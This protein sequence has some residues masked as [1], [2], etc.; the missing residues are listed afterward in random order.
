[1]GS[2]EKMNWE[3]EYTVLDN[4]NIEW[5]ISKKFT[6]FMHVCSVCRGLIWVFLIFIL[7][8]LEGNSGFLFFMSKNIFLILIN[9]I[10]IASPVLL[11]ELGI[12]M[13]APIVT[14][15]AIDFDNEQHR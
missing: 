4:T 6:A 8:Y 11:F 2:L 12:L 10:L 7:I 3:N 5:R 13:Y 14:K 9:L 1:M 15:E